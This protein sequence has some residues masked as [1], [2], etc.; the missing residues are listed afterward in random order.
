[1]DRTI[2]RAHPCAAGARK[3]TAATPARL[4]AGVVEVFQPRFTWPLMHWAIRDA[5]FSLPATVMIARKHLRCL[6]GA[7]P[8]C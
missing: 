7:L 6:K 5:S 3:K 4:E 1:M 2:M 8:R